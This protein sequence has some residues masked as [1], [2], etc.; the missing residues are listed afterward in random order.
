[1]TLVKGAAEPLYAQLYTQLRAAIVAG[2]RW[3]VGARLPASRELANELGVS[4]N[5][6]VLAYQRLAED[7]F[8]H[9]MAGGGTVV[10]ELPK[11]ASDTSESTTVG[12]SAAVENAAVEQAQYGLPNSAFPVGVPPV[13]LFPTA[14]WAGLTSRR[15]RTSGV[16]VLLGSGRLGYRPLREAIAG[17][18]WVVRGIRC[19]AEQV[20]VTRG[21]DAGLDLLGRVLARRGDQ[22]WCEEP[23]YYR[24]VDALTRQGLRCVPVRVDAQGMAV[25]LAR[26]RWPAATM[27]MV[28]AA[29]QLPLSV[30]MSPA[31]RA[32]LL[33][34]AR[35]T[36]MWIVEHEIDTAFLGRQAVG[37]L[38]ADDTH[39]RVIHVGGFDSVLF[40]QLHV[41]YCVVP[42]ELIEPVG[43]ELVDAGAQASGV[44]QAVLADFLN[45]HRFARFLTRIASACATRRDA[46]RDT[47]L[48]LPDTP[49]TLVGD[50]RGSSVTALFRRDVRE[51]GLIADAARQSLHLVP[52]SRYFSGTG[53]ATTGLLLGC[54]AAR[55]EAIGPAVR[56]LAGLLRRHS[57][58]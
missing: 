56:L 3:A 11:L 32:L 21:L 34:H 57:R 7:G 35:R 58:P 44:T 29:C 17:Y 23:G 54:A 13:D 42:T 24:G 53:P 15:L 45:H 4:R 37:P 51:D 16:R 50:G 43:R 28:S 47:L 27:A 26:E 20:I 46:L 14:L 39:G 8:V 55:E 52:L 30:S 38:I 25:D 2:E 33:D 10:A 18:L 48:R 49:L 31:R 40:P 22:V 5:T 12:N 19:S 41:G 6:V 1:M 36:G 9:G